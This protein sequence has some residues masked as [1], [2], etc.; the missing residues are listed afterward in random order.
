MKNNHIEGVGALD[1]TQLQASYIIIK[2]FAHQGYVA[3]PP[4]GPQLVGVHSI[5][6]GKH[7]IS[8]K[9]ESGYLMATL[10]NRWHEGTL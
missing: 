6:L 9:H 2:G 3:C 5:K 8:K 7:C 10:Y 1:N 4:C